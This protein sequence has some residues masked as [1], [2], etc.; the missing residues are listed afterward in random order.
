MLT[1]KRLA[2]V[3]QLLLVPLLRTGQKPSDAPVTFTS[4]VLSVFQSLSLQNVDNVQHAYLS[5]WAYLRC[6]FFLAALP[7]VDLSPSFSWLLHAL[8]LPRTSWSL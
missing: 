7:R 8:C 4:S 1:G 2:A 6:E 3:S 5:R